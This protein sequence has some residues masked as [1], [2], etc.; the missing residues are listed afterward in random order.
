VAEVVVEVGEASFADE[1]IE[2]S[3]EQPVVVD[4]WAAWCG[5]CRVLGPTLEALAAE[6]GGA[7]RLAKVD[8]DA[9]PGLASRY[10]ISG[11]PA[12]K[13][14][15]GG[16]LV[17]EFVGALPEP[18]VREFFAALLPSATDDAVQAAEA[19]RAAGDLLEARRLF[20][21]ALEADPQHEEAA[22]GLAE[23][24]LESGAPAEAERAMQLASRFEASPRARRVEGL[25]RFGSLG[26]GLDEGELLGRIAQDEGDAEAHYRLGGLLAARGEWETALEELLATVRL[27]RALDDDGG[28]RAMLDV[29]NVLGNRDPLTEEYRRRL[30]SVIF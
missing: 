13:A 21:E 14:F 22:L 15:A 18:Q 24:L 11:I 30:A 12:V 10:G 1:V 17:S 7:V 6:Y 19:A 25:A 20:D 28:R 16:E 26:A 4:F 23:L 2:A 29:F 9:N 8:V 27:D 3:R 5:P